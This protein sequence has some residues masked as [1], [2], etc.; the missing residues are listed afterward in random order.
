[1]N[2]INTILVCSALMSLLLWYVMRC[3]QRIR[4]NIGERYYRWHIQQFSLLLLVV[5]QSVA[6][7]HIGGCWV[8]LTLA[9]PLAC[10]IVMRKLLHRCRCGSVLLSD[11]IDIKRNPHENSSHLYQLR[12]R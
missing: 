12:P 2:V 8:A 3:S 6:S 10:L 11:G 7:Y 4:S 9:A 5:T 1:M